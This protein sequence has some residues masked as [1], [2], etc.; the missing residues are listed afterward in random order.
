[1]SH[2]PRSFVARCAWIGCLSWLLHLPLGQASEV[3]MGETLPSQDVLAKNLPGLGR[4]VGRL[5][6]EPGP[7]QAVFFLKEGTLLETVRV[8]RLDT[9]LWTVTP[10]PDGP[11]RLVMR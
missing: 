1:M 4:Y 3:Y 6:E 9:K 10:V 5:E 7:C 2:M 8:C 11:T